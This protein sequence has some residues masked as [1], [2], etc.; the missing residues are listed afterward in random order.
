MVILGATAI[1]AVGLNPGTASAAPTLVTAERDCTLLPTPIRLPI[2]VT[3]G[4]TVPNSVGL[5]YQ[6]AQ[7]RVEG[8]VTIPTADLIAMGA[9]TIEGTINANLIMND[10]GKTYR[11]NLSFGFRKIA[12]TSPTVSVPLIGYAKETQFDK[13]GIATVEVDAIELTLRPIR[14]DGTR[15]PVGELAGTCTSDHG[16]DFWHRVEVLSMYED[17]IGAPGGIRATDVTSTSVSVSWSLPGNNMFGKVIGSKL[18]VDEVEVARIDNVTDLTAT[19]TG[20]TPDTDYWIRVSAITT[21]GTTGGSAPIKV[22][23]LPGS[24]VHHFGLSGSSSVK[25]AKTTVP[26]TGTVSTEL[27]LG[28]GAHT[29]AITLNPTRANAILFG[30]LPMSADIAFITASPSTGTLT[31]GVLTST[32]KVTIALPKV[33]LFGIPVSQSATCKTSAPAEIA[34]TSAPGFTPAA[35]GKLTGTFV[36]PALTGCGYLTSW[37]S[38][39]VAGPG[40]TTEITLAPGN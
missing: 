38:S 23:T 20:L 32:S 25:A 16:P 7:E 37:L 3:L 22:S 17:G 15:P 1:A 24:V 13:P 14:G 35:G 2:S 28:T 29:S 18:I 27:D 36:I 12:L 9:T 4:V 40:N 34:L 31:G 10:P 39:V 21:F 6:H 11:A 30:V 19:I 26:L 33:T 8:T 5:G